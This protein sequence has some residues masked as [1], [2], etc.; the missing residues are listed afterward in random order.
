MRDFPPRRF[1]ATSAATRKWRRSSD[2]HLERHLDSGADRGERVAE[3][4]G[5]VGSER[6]SV[7]QVLL[8]PAGQLGEGAFEVADLVLA[9]ARLESAGEPAAAVEDL[10]CP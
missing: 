2:L 7:L 1:G 8:E 6:L 5:D 10:A 9:P 4:V 3:L